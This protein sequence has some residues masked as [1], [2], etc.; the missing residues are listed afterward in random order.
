MALRA[1]PSPTHTVQSFTAKRLSFNLPFQ[2]FCVCFALVS[3]F[4][5]FFPTHSFL[6]LLL[7]LLPL[8]SCVFAFLV[9]ETC[10]SYH[11]FARAYAAFIL[12]CVCVAHFVYH[13]R[14]QSCFL[15]LMI[16]ALH[17]RGGVGSCI[18]VLT[19]L[20]WCRC[21]T[22]G[23]VRSCVAIMCIFVMPCRFVFLYL[24]RPDVHLGA[25]APG[26]AEPNKH[27]FIRPTFIR[28]P[29]R[30]RSSLFLQQCLFLLQC[31]VT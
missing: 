17:M 10:V 8:L 26:I 24:L 14:V 28:H 9:I 19:C 22:R 7:L 23:V 30:L 31:T 1:M 15:Y 4:L 18:C 3:L 25:E 27:T 20:C 11:T 21:M 29:F 2:F 5:I 16:C 13:L 12:S 6:L